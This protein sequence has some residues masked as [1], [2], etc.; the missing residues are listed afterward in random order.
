MEEA[1]QAGLG[2]FARATGLFYLAGGL[3]TLRAGRMESFLDGAIARLEEQPSDRAERL[4]GVSM[5]IIGA[6][7]A[8]SGLMLALL[9]KWALY[10]FLA[11]AA[12]QAAYIAWAARALPP[13]TPLAAAGRRRTINAFVVWLVMIGLVLLLFGRGVLT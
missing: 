6:L 4:R 1:L 11:N 12:W 3:L 13:G 10:A 9:L 8:V 5:M 7:T 2:W